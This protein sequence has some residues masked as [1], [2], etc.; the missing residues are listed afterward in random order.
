MEASGANR[1]LV[2]AT[3]GT[4]HHRFDRLVTWIDAW[5]E[6]GGAHHADC[7]IQIGTSKRPRNARYSTYM[8]Y[9]EVRRAMEQA[10]VVVSHA[11]PASILLAHATGKLP[12]VVPRTRA[13][14]EHVD[15]HQMAFAR[16]AARAGLIV[17][18]ETE[19]EFRHLLDEMLAGGEG[20]REARPLETGAVG[21]FE[22][23]IGDLVGQ[24][25]EGDLATADVQVLYVGGCGRSGSTL[26][27]TLL[28][29]APGVVAV[30]ELRHLWRAI[31]RAE[32]CGCGKPVNQC[33][34]WE[35]VGAVAF[36][37]WSRVDIRRHLQLDQ[38]VD[39]HRRIPGLV[40]PAVR[41][42]T[43]RKALREYVRSLGKLYRGI[44][45]VSGERIVLDSTK[46]PCYGFLLR[47]VDGVSVR[48]IHLVRDSRGVAYSWQK[49]TVK[50]EVPGAVE[51]MDR[52]SPSR[53]ALRWS[54]Y[55]SLL[56]GLRALGVPT[57]FVKYEDFVADPRGIAE[58]ALGFAGLPD[59]E[60]R[61]P[62]PT[63]NL[64]DLAAQHTIAGNP[65]RFHLNGHGIALDDEWRLRMSRGSAR[66]VTA[67]SAPLLAAYG[68]MGAHRNGDHPADAVD[69]TGKVAS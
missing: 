64:S 40:V 4:D 57:M 2:F 8:P 23:A 36:G 52:Y 63:A 3:V 53:M 24:A 69:D 61:V 60:I 15:D 47:N 28:G 33:P 26:V 29:G 54:A 43:T 10:A 25:K 45:T 66:R 17:L 58:R 38:L 56:H 11:G 19:E 59:A 42:P 22:D 20:K 51:Y 5:L 62:D 39:R 13:G 18:P 30:G 34:F 12:V 44:S 37:G 35:E 27:S 67:L 46:D 16:R 68:Y 55:N 9:E 41:S 21:R 65:M 48:M 14:R 6:A 50:P 31:D 1:P 7:L 32:L 49:R